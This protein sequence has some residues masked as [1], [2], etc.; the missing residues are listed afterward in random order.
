[1]TYNNVDSTLFFNYLK[2]T[3]HVL[4]SLSLV[5]IIH[6]LLFIIF[7]GRT[8]MIK[9]LIWILSGVIMVAAAFR[10]FFKSSHFIKTAWL[11]IIFYGILTLSAVLIRSYSDLF[12][13]SKTYEVLSSYFVASANA[14]LILAF[15]L[16]SYTKESSFKTRRVLNLLGLILLTIVIISYLI[17]YNPRHDGAGFKAMIRATITG[18]INLS[19]FIMGLGIYWMSIWKKDIKR[20]AVFLIILFST[21]ISFKLISWSMR[22]LSLFYKGDSRKK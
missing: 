9:D 6:F 20:K 2:R 11:Y 7:P 16:F 22:L 5:L 1:M 19:P 14:A 10:A 4:L 18:V 15:F 8:V 12:S 3:W 13:P 17:N 21:F